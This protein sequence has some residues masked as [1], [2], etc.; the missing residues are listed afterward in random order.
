MK[1]VYLSKHRDP[2][3]ASDRIAHLFS[4]KGLHP[5]GETRPVWHALGIAVYPT[6][7]VPGM[8]VNEPGYMVGWEMGCYPTLEAPVA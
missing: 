4:G 5:E 3:G 7:D 6:N 1:M 2:Y 8:V